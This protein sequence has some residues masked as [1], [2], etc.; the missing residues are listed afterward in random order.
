MHGERAHWSSECLR[1]MI[2]R[3][4]SIARKF[5]RKATPESGVSERC[6]NGISNAEKMFFSIREIACRYR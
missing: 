4:L 1:E 6:P 2:L 3:S 5:A